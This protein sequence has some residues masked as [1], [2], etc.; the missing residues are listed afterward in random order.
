M[1]QVG[2][3]F[4]HNYK[5]VSMLKWRILFD[6][7]NHLKMNGAKLSFEM[8]VRPATIIAVFKRCQSGEPNPENK[9]QVL[10]V[11]QS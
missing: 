1:Q 3:L 8:G 4:I 2:M 10:V 5:C 7:V 6:L 9:S 11:L